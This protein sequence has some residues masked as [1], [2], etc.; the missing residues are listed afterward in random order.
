[1]RLLPV[2][3]IAAASTATAQPAPTPAPKLTVVISVDQFSSDLFDQYAPVLQGGFA[4]LR[5]GTVYPRAY[6]GH[7]ASETCPG[8]STILT[9]VHP[10]R[11][12]IIA[13]V[14]YDLSQTRS[15]KAVYCAE[16]ERV[17]GT[18]SSA[19]AVSPMHLKVPTLGEYM[20]RQWPTSRT[21]AV[22]GKDR[23]AVMMSGQ[24]PDQRWYWNGKTFATDLKGA[25]I[26]QSL[27]SARTA[28]ANLVA[29][30]QAPLEPP[31]LCSS[32]AQDVAVAGGGQP[33]GA[34]RFAR[35]AGDLTLFRASP[36]FDGATMALAA[37]LVR[38][39]KLGKGAAPDLLTLGLSATDYVGHRYGSGG[40]E[41]C[42]QLLS[43]DRDLG[44]FLAFLDREVGDYSVVL[45]ADHGGK[46]IP[47]RER[48]AGVAGAARVDPS[49]SASNVGKAL[50]T[51]FGLPG[52]VLYG[53]NFG[54][55]YV[56]RAA[57]MGQRARVLAAAVAIYR[58][59]PQVAAVFTHDLLDRTAMPTSAP[60]KWS[61]IER[62]RASFDASRSGDFVVL[63]KKDIT[64]IAD[65][66]GGYVATHG[67]VWDY[68]RRVPIIFWRSGYGAKSIDQPVETV[69]I[70]PTIAAS[71]GL[72]LPAGAVDGKCLADAPGAVCPAR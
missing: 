66:K 11:S 50:A 37:G 54:D 56:D 13:N 21:I 33:V 14:W 65:T 42:L 58:A 60:D 3:L 4:R 71:M 59:H 30:P 12:G 24:Q 52:S 20:K 29:Q 26:P 68:D 45:T 31:A 70:L 1:M 27:T 32:K 49:I 62:A 18:S 36:A 38:E 35:A 22:A 5:Q 17:A 34:G 72:A 2:L 40:Q 67:S 63:L 47:E 55:I 41:M 10:A 28:V 48:A 64:P 15:D 23:A 53:S 57:A 9:G 7:A 39:M 69:D 19:Y 25:A 44:D 46:D 61:L 51:K 8:H 43:L 16:D 6:Q